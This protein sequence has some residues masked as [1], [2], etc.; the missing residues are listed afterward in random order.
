MLEAARAKKA[1]GTDVVIGWVETHGRARDRGARRGPRAA[2]AARGR[3]PGHAPPGVRPRRRARPQARRSSCSTSSP[4]PTR[5]G[6]RHAK[7]WQ[8]VEELLDAGIDVYT[9][10]NVQHLE[11]LNDLVAQITGVVVRETRAR[12]P[13]RRRGRG[14]SSSTCPPTTCC[15]ASRRA[16]ST[17]RTAGGARGRRASSARAT[18]SRCASW[19]CGAPPSAW[20]PTCATTG[21]TT[22]SR[23]P[24]R[25]PSASWSASRPN[26][27]SAGWCAP[28][29]AWRARLHA[30]WI[31]VYV[32]SPAQPPALGR[33][34]RAPWPPP[35]SSPSSSARRRRTCP[36]SSVERGAAA[37]SRA[38]ATSARSWSASRAHGRWRDR[39][40][41]SLVD[42]IVRGSGEIDVYVISG[43]R[44]GE[45]Q[46]RAPVRGRARRE[47]RR[48]TL[49]SAA[50]VARLHAPLLGDARPLRPLEPGHGLPA[51]G[52]L[53]RLASRAAAPRRLTGLLS[54]AAFDFFFVPP[55]LTF[56]VTDTQY[57]VT[58]AVMLLVAC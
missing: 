57:L 27:E 47:A 50:V 46:P 5:A 14:P 10:L 26:P 33:R 31:A 32:E 40:R 48:S 36:A 28:R 19:R 44:E 2:P 39:L 35:P 53:R 8:D 21:A 25:W 7:R 43:E 1:E 23:R 45:P 11:S 12:P 24:G 15:S 29:G 54:V 6:S 37:P 49:W 41:G 18:S 58:F 55:Y 42:E 9:T 22:R 20:T 51:R 38:S 34:A 56:A 52:R 3:V 13:P 17:C 16:R 4:T 30:E